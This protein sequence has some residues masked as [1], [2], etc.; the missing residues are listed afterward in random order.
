MLVIDVSVG[1]V[2]VLAVV[3]GAVVGVLVSD[4][5]RIES[6]PNGDIIFKAPLD[7]VSHLV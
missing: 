2:D 6:S 7:A 3:V 1:V 5:D 4:K